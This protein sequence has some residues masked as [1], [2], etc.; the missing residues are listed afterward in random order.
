M[1][2]MGPATPNLHFVVS[3]PEL[4]MQLDGQCNP[5]WFRS[6]FVANESGRNGRSCFDVNVIVAYRGTVAT[7]S[8]AL[9]VT[10]HMA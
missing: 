2:H 5:R 9:E 7:D 8:G 4:Q 3:G 6:M 1:L 10:A